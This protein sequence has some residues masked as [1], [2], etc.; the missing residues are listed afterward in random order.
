MRERREDAGSSEE[1]GSRWGDEGGEAL[2][3]GE[4]GEREV[5][6][7][8]ADGALQPKQDVAAAVE[9]EAARG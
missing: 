8:V 9:G 4:R 5:R 1:M 3:E 7:A 6:R 2:E